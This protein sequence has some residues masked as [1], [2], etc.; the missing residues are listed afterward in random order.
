MNF[1]DDMMKF[2]YLRQ[3]LD[4]Q[5]KIALDGLTLTKANYREAVKPVRGGAV[6][7]NDS[8]RR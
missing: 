4:G 5:A 7:G 1:I 2:T 8:S 3:K 6:S